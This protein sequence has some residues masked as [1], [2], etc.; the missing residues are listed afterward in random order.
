MRSLVRLALES[1]GYSVIEAPD[2]GEAISVARQPATPIDMVLTDLVMPGMSGRELAES[3]VT[4]R[5]ELKV[6]LMSGYTDDEVVRHGI[7]GSSA[8]IQKPFLPN[9]AR[10]QGARGARLSR[11]LTAATE[12]RSAVRGAHDDVAHRAGQHGAMAREFL[13][14]APDAL[15]PAAAS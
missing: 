2:P 4:T 5:P 1:A 14:G 9:E 11:P 6:L 15:A 12:V 8:F 3:L 13:P 7:S 10:G